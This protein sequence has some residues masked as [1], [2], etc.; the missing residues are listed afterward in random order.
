M[1]A[2]GVKGARKCKNNNVRFRVL[3]PDL[4]LNEALYGIE[5]SPQGVGV[6]VENAFDR[7]AGSRKILV[8]AGFVVSC[9]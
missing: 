4:F 6:A 7:Q 3:L 5:T 2:G 9:S 8:L 1:E